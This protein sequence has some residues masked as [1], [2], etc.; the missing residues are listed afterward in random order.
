MVSEDFQIVG[1]VV[2]TKI[3]I[4][5]PQSRVR[6]GEC[7]AGQSG[8]H[9]VALHNH[10]KEIYHLNVSAPEGATELEGIAR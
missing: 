6:F 2:S 9:E 10:V 8:L 3:T 7:G 1:P 5:I 4:H